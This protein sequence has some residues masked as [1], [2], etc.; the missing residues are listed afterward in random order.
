LICDNAE[1]LWHLYNI[2]FK[3]DFIKT[4]TFRKVTHENTMGTKSSS[5]KKK[6]NITIK[7]EEVEYDQAEGIIRYKGKN[8]SENEY[9]SIGQYQSIEIGKG[10]QFTIFKKC[11]DEFSIEKLREAVDVVTASDLAACVMEEGVAHLFLISSHLTNLKAKIEC[12]IPKK[13]KGPSQHDKSLT[14]FFQKILDAIV[15][16]VNFDI[17]K[18]VIVA[19]PGFTKDQFG[20]YLTDCVSNNK[21]YEIVQKNLSKFVYTHA[22]NGYKQ[23]LQEVLAKPEVLSQIKNTKAADDVRTMEKFNETLWK[24][25][26]RVIFGIKAVEIA[27]EKEAIDTLIVSDDYLRKISPLRRKE[28]TVLMNKIKGYGGEVVK[29]SSMHYTGEKINSFGGITAILKYALEMHVDEDIIDTEDLEKLN[30]HHHEDIEADDLAMLNLNE[31]KSGDVLEEEKDEVE[32][33]D[34]DEE[35]YGDLADYDKTNVRVNAKHKGKPSKM[36]KKE[37]EQNRKFAARKK[38]S[39]DDE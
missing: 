24:D 20:N 29:M 37:R 11:W 33:D 22:S 8:V 23:A 9:I 28:L 26:D 36:E 10:I 34:E 25:M 15:K 4:V 38:S 13:R 27:T 32:E 7:V 12:S 14:S 6:I 35:E 31:K 1:D 16:N 39:F 21:H 2:I 19:G 5:V 30:D 17:V 18:C 3:G